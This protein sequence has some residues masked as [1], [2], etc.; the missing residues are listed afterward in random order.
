MIAVV[1]KDK[2]G[3]RYGDRSL[4]P[5]GVVQSSSMSASNVGKY[6]KNSRVC[7]DTMLH[8]YMPK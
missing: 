5:H 1:V 8:P 4:S 2:N 3:N 6:F 7:M